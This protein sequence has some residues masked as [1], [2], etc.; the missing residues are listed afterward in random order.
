MPQTFFLVAL[1]Q[2]FYFL[3]TGV[4][5]LINMATFEA[6]TGAKFDDWLVKT[7]GVLVSVIGGVLAIAAQR[8][9]MLSMW[10]SSGLLQ[11]TCWM[12]WSR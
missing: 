11:S 9:Q 1:A 6:I 10:R 7:V 3:P 4:W 12:R 2:A 5:P 8:R